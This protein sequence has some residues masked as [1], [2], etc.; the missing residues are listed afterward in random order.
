MACHVIIFDVFMDAAAHVNSTAHDALDMRG[1]VVDMKK[2]S[3][4]QRNA[5]L[6]ERQ[7]EDTGNLII[8][9]KK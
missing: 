3:M 4:P 2:K 8:M 5:I 6:V 9:M 1:T 7:I